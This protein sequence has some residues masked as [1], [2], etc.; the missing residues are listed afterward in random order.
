[1]RR[2]ARLGAATF[3]LALG[4]ALAVGPVA[5]AQDSG[6]A[7]LVQLPS[8]APVIKRVVPAVVN[9]QVQ[10]RGDVASDDDD[11][12]PGQ[13]QGIPRGSPFDQL[14]RRFFEQQG[15]NPDHIPQQH[16]QRTALGSGFI[17]DPSG[18]IV[19]NN[20]VVG[21]AEK[22]TVIFQDDSRHTAKIIGKD[23]K[24]DL[25]L[26][27][28]ETDHPLP[29]V[30]WGDSNASQI[31]D[32]VVAV[33]NPF[34]LGGTVSAGIISARGRDIHSGPYDDFLQIDAPINRGNSGGPTFNLQGQVI[35]INTA[36]YSPNGGSVG[37]GFAIPSSLARPVIEEL[38]NKGKVSRGWLGVQ[39]Q[40]VTPALAK[41]LDLPREGGA[42]VADVTKGSPAAKAG[43]EQGDVIESFNGH[44][45]Q[46]V[47]D[48]PILVAETPIGT[49]AKIGVWRHGKQIALS[50]EVAEQPDNLGVASRDT[51]GGSNG[52]SDQQTTQRASALGLKLAP[53]TA[54]LRKQVR[55]PA[56]IKGVVVTQIDD[57]SPLADLDLQ[58]GDVIV[59]INQEPVATPH[60]AVTKLKAAQVNKSVLLQIN[61]HGINAFVAW[62]GST[63]NG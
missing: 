20:H 29:Y 3:A 26:I 60:D 40:E 50:S 34:G 19:T 62:S 54:D 32:W 2:L 37:I 4:L 53:L 56:N 13:F 21:D 58:V 25:A 10:E 12:S 31:G 49:L 6:G 17:V 47:R 24:T 55:A 57:S 5:H 8:L 61:R 52:G 22:V 11:S 51:G 30:T 28:I 41:S 39:I 63:D 1:M 27:K 45:I 48:L 9:I 14:L 7:P 36:I 16:V 38:K 43:F 18:Y 42:L 33:G 59:A 15:I 46:K 23:A 35:G 44:D